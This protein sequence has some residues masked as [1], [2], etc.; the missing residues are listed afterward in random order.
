M[1]LFNTLFLL[2]LLNALCTGPV[3]TN[4]AQSIILGFFGGTFLAVAVSGVLTWCLDS[5]TRGTLLIL[6][7]DLSLKLRIWHLND[8]DLFC[9][10]TPKNAVYSYREAEVILHMM[11]L[12]K[13]RTEIVNEITETR[14]KRCEEHQQALTDA[15]NNIGEKVTK[16]A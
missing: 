5:W 6:E 9:V 2:K 13:V 14:E 8:P 4:W 12:A 10:Y 7:K 1:K 16:Y 15:V 3:E 11:S